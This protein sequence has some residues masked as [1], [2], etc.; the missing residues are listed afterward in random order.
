MV[1]Q[2]TM[3]NRSGILALTL[4]FTAAIP[5]ILSAEV[6]VPNL[7]GDHMVF[8]R[9]QPV[10]VWGKAD[11]GEW[12]EVSLAGRTARTAAGES[13]D[14]RV[15][16]PP[17]PAGGPHT[18]EVIGASNSLRKQDVLVGEV[19]VGSGQSNMQWTLSRC[20]DGDLAEL[21]VNRA[22]QIRLL[23]VKNPGSQE[24]QY[25]P[26]G[27]WT[28]AAPDTIG[29]FSAVAY[30]F[31]LTLHDTL[32]VPVGIIENSWGG[33]SAEAWVPRPV[34]AADPDLVQIHERWLETEASH[35]YEAELQEYQEA[36]AKWETEAAQARE[37]GASEPAKPRKP[38]DR[39][40]G[41]H[42]PGNLWNARVLPVAPFSVR[43][44]IWYQGESNAGRAHEYQH[45]FSTLIHEWRT[46]WGAEL[47]FYWVQLA[48]FRAESV[49]S[50][51]DT[52]P[53][54]REAQTLTMHALPHTGQ[55][56]IIDVGEGRDIHPRQKET[57]ARRLA[58]W[59]LN[60]DYG[61]SDLACRS[62][63]LAS[64][65]QQGDRVVLRF[66]HVGG[67]LR[68]FDTAEVTGFVVRTGNSG[69]QVV[70]GK[71]T[72]KDLVELE[73][74][75]DEPVTAVRYAW[76]DNP[77]RNLFSHEGLPVTPFRTDAP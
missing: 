9:D 59:A 75:D 47:P 68:A 62:P 14:W 51:E 46:A 5:G 36:L 28:V 35:D 53:L 73:L 61:F 11:P 10:R 19:W 60:R 54:L 39:M 23:R 43:G 4:V 25:G 77:V 69:W 38:S 20:L 3:K 17:L 29:S 67:G 8:Q 37:K 26:E 40:T 72:D 31:A 1:T 56:V 42:R 41:Q 64:W 58:R 44:V 55:A 13:G 22:P 65:R 34:I 48:D 32:N 71:V 15:E 45:L 33:S 57:V 50:E 76:A 27:E 52:W 74:E 66:D 7:F 2:D 21:T 70:S 63:E 49:F 18:L 12:I 16:L 30:H 6:S 24:P